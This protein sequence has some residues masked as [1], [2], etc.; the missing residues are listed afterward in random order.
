MITRKDPYLELGFRNQRSLRR[1]IDKR[2]TLLETLGG[3]CKLGKE[4]IVYAGM[5]KDPRSCDAYL[6]VV[7][8]ICSHLSILPIH[9]IRR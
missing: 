5:Y 9:I 3:L 2:V 4:L 6:P 8:A 7:E 1:I